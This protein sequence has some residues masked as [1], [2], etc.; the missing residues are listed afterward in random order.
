MTRNEL[1]AA[2]GVTPNT[3]YRWERSK[4][5]DCPI[6]GKKPRFGCYVYTDTELAAL[7]EWMT[8]TV[9][10]YEVRPVG[11]SA[12]PD[13]LDIIEGAHRSQVGATNFCY[14][15]VPATRDHSLFRLVI[16]R[17]T[18]NGYYP[19][20]D[21]YFLGWRKEGYAEADRLNRDRLALMP[22]QA[23]LI[24]A[25]SMAQRGIAA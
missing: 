1:A 3:I 20:S 24:V 18:E 6:E 17:R 23:A 4:G 2:L 14:W 15:A 11:L 25:D 8:A 19:V 12:Q 9:P 5:R 21:D 13:Y 16:V 10:A 22:K 7:R